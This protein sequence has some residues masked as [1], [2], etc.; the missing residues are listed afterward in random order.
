MNERLK[1]WLSPPVFPD[2]ED[3]D[4]KARILHTLQV[5]MLAALSFAFLGVFFIFENKILSLVLV[6]VMLVFVLASYW[7]ALRGHILAAS[8]LFVSELWVVFSLAILFTGRFNTSYV[9]LHLAVVVMAGVLLGMRSTITFSLLSILYGLGLAL[10]ESAGYP[11]A[12]YFP[13]Q[14][15]AGWFTWVLSFILILTPL[16]PTIQNIVH[17]IAALREKQRFIESILSATP[18]IIHIFD[19]Q[20]RRSVFSSRSLLAALGY[21][22]AQ[23]IADTDLLHPEDRIQRPNL[24]KQAETA[25][26]GETL[27]A[28][29]RMRTS[30]NDW[31]WFL[32]RD[33]VFR[34]GADG[35]SQQLIGIIIDITERKQLEAELERLATTDPLTG[36]LNRRQL[37]SLAMVELGR[38]ARYGHFTSVIM[39]DIDYFKR[40]NDIYGHATGDEVLAR[41][42]QLLNKIAR[43]SDLVARYGGEEFVLVLPETN[44]FSAQDVAERI[45]QTIAETV[46]SIKEQTIRIT[47]SLGVTSSERGTQDF[48]ALLKDADQLLY[49]AK[50][51]GR[52]RVVCYTGE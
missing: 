27:T 44:I 28:E 34:R 45:R 36:V 48:E 40:I 41:L 29:Y 22:Q 30:S 13:V 50:Q 46:F 4:Q 31:R 37:V 17:S 1:T 23:P 33:M 35:K 43:T 38:A 11:L 51:A 32:E 8:R 7:L 20:E 10:L 5:S 16:T 21:K 49:Q 12:R 9:S 24:F 3:K 25:K 39:L 42:S 14:P 26:D 52:D 18:N 15:L 47:V 19:L 2:D 6:I